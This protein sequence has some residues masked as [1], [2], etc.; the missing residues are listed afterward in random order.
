MKMLLPVFTYMCTM[1]Y[2]YCVYMHAF[3]GCQCCDLCNRK[4]A[5]YLLTLGEHY[6]AKM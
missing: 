2:C 6:Y 4:R 3:D 1:D 5:V